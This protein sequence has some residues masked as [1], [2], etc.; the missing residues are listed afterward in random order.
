MSNVWEPGDVIEHQE[1][2]K[3]EG[4]KLSAVRGEHIEMKVRVPYNA[5]ALGMLGAI[6]A[7]GGHCDIMVSHTVPEPVVSA[8][9]LDEQRQE[10]MDFEDEDEA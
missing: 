2:V 1:R 10:R 7:N 8:E 5:E 3:I 9:E 6:Y 4:V